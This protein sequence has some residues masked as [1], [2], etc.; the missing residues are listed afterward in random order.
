M[1][2]ATRIRSRIWSRRSEAGEEGDEDSKSRLPFRR[3]FPCDTFDP[4][5]YEWLCIHTLIPIWAPQLCP[6]LRTPLHVWTKCR[7]VPICR[8]I[9]A[10]P[11]QPLINNGAVSL[12]H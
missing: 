9:Q 7:I 1:S 12:Y 6:E 4:L 10:A 5:R 8:L 11:G 2:E 3:A